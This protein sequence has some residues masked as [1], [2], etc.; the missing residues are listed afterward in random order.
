VKFG[1]H[2][3]A[4]WKIFLGDTHF[5]K[6]IGKRRSGGVL[7][8]NVETEELLSYLRERA[9]TPSDIN[10][11]L[12]LLYRIVAETNAQ[13][14]VELGVRGGNSTCALVIGAAETGG[15][16]TSVDH[17]KGAA[18][19][20][21]EPTWDSLAQASVVIN[22]KLDLSGYW[23]LVVRD[24]LE[25]AREYDDE[26]DV[27][28][29]DTS[30]SYE[31]T[32]KELEAWGSKVVTGGFIVI[33]DTVSFPEQNKAIWEFMD[34]H[35][36]SDYVEHK[37]CNGL[38]IIIKGK[39]TSGKAERRI[40]RI[41]SDAWRYRLDR[42]QEA[43]VE[44]RAFLGKK[45]RD[46]LEGLANQRVTLES[47]LT[48]R[49]KDPLGK[50][51]WT[52][53]S[54]P[55]LQQA[56]PEVVD[57]DYSRLLDWAKEHIPSG[58]DAAQQVLRTHID[59]Y[60]TNALI[61][62]R[63]DNVELKQRLE[64]LESERSRLNDELSLV[65]EEL[66]AIK[67]SFGYNTLHFFTTHTDRLLPNNTRR[68]ELRKI[69]V[70]SLRIAR[71]QGVRSLI[72]QALE[73]IRRREFALVG[74][75]T[76]QGNQYDVWLSNNQ[77]TEEK[78]A[79]TR[80]EIS[81]FGYKPKISIVMPVYNPEEKELEAAISSVTDQVYPNWELC[82]VDDAST[83]KHIRKVLSEQARRDTRIRVKYLDTNLGISGA[84]NEALKMASGEFVGFLDHD[85]ELTKDALFEVVKA[86]NDNPNEDLIY[87]DEDKMDLNDRRVEPFFKPD[88]SPD[89][90]LSMNYI[91]HFC[92][93][94]KNLIEKI[95]GFRKGSEGSQDY[96]L[97][98]RVTEQTNRIFHISRQLYSWRKTPRSAAAS[99]Q[100]KPYAYVSAKRAILE[101][102]T[103]RG[104]HAD[105]EDG[106]YTGFYRV[107][108][109]IDSQLV[110]IIIPTK[111][112]CEL[113]RR[114]LTS[115]ESKSTYSNYEIIVVDNDSDDPETLGYLDQLRR[116]PR[117]IILSFHD[118]FGY[119]RIINLATRHA[120]GSHMVFLNNDTEVVTADWIQAMLEH[121]Q[122][123]SVGAVGAKLI[124]PDGKIQHA[125]VILGL[126]G[127][128]GHAFY[129]LPAGNPGY[130]GLPHVIRN[131]SAVTAA[132]MM[133]RRD[134]F[135]NLNGFDEGFKVEFGD[136]DFC[137][138]AGQRGYSI[139]YT[140]Y[141]V[142]KHHEGAT[143]G[144]YSPHLNDRKLFAE[145][146]GHLLLDGDPYYNPNLSLLS[147]NYA[148]S[149][150]GPM[151][152]PLSVLLDV[153]NVRPDLQKAFPEAKSGD[154][155]RLVG[156]AAE[157]GVDPGR[158]VL[159]PYLS[160][161]LSNATLPLRPSQ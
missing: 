65:R 5:V 61:R 159:W 14:I 69:V 27:L 131:C 23:M 146:W 57:G 115:I 75:E 6:Q 29:I 109:G 9:Q 26:I 155:R 25:F 118:E 154:Y 76:S 112:R 148:V 153:Y 116:L 46:A 13:K 37:N 93:I 156:W 117:H 41:G 92:V 52:Y 55:D 98:L 124:F 18:Y 147:A 45:D 71:K 39:A 40:G 119:S 126:G 87:S 31:Q 83:K 100:A 20:G 114:C 127:L 86:L 16:V 89:L 90:L 68:G 102:L 51:L 85:D 28:M 161:Y 134:V 67:D 142:L 21:E 140:P 128:A 135:Q 77:L 30:H 144:R 143:R 60:Q 122:R 82:A 94:R 136:V 106:A 50:L 35:Q 66:F 113:L 79:K 48:K 152:R 64:T 78:L 74:M 70:A 132:C 49:L 105:V 24:D 56:F 103:R 4:E 72:H 145:R 138:R 63:T 108:Y 158:A 130:F 157:D 99:I 137:L 59:W 129:N 62:M 53:S 160:Y 104:I 133:V 3:A 107:R 54:R 120:N 38:G 11:H 8:S 34:E 80:E 22:D 1:F 96:E 2:E 32:R 42:M 47:E 150:H 95:G 141:A 121:S 15:H 17:G 58:K 151:I 19:S 36:F 81:R 43:I 88:W 110:S 44:M 33:H 125:G 139:V 7:R 101:A 12:E 97:I 84:S 111:N 123:N 149:F 73:K 10:E 91:T